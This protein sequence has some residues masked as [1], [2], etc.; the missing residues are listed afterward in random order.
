[1]AAI[2]HCARASH[3]WSEPGDAA[4]GLALAR[5]ALAGAGD[6]PATLRLAGHAIAYLGRD[7][8]A[9]LA[10]IGRSVAINPNS[11]Q[12][13][14]S[15]GWVYSYAGDPAGAIPLFR[16]AV[17]LS[18]RDPE[19]GQMRAGE[20]LA[21]LMLGDLPTALRCAEEGVRQAQMHSGCHR[22]L[23]AALWRL[24][25]EAEAR[26]AAQAF[27]RLEPWTRVGR[28]TDVWRDRGFRDAY[29]AD[30]RAAGLPE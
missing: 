4:S 3:Q 14:S 9:A 26:E 1:M 10:A 15:A 30:L 16:R 22:A 18:P 6:D 24:G 12:A 5:E 23:I 25:R 7:F 13:A 29:W 28:M 17:R 8:E 2:C 21:Q 11:A 20:A 19:I 27:L